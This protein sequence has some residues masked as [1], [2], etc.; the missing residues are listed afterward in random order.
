MRDPDT[1]E[2]EIAIERERLA[3]SLRALDQSLSPQAIVNRAAD[4]LKAPAQGATDLARNNPLALAVIGSGLAWLM[5]GTSNDK[6]AVNGGATGARPIAADD[7]P[8]AR[9]QKRKGET[10]M[11][12]TETDL[13]QS[14]DADGRAGGKRQRLRQT[15]EELRARLHD[16]MENLPD[17]ARARILEARLKAIEAQHAVEAKIARASGSVQR[18]AQENPFLVGAIAFGLGAALAA[19]MP[20]SS[21]ENRSIGAHRDRLLDDAER[22]FREETAKLRRVAETAVEEG[23]AAVKDTL[24]DG[25][26]DTENP[27]DRVRKAAREEADRQDLGKTH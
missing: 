12:M 13:H 27:A 1:I 21:I 25:V 23:K 19:A 20:R 16:G 3:Q 17:A 8:N 24:R 14:R 22:V 11:T 4:A 18:N 15:A 9:R 10:V 26:S 2:R 5:A 7:A 6:D